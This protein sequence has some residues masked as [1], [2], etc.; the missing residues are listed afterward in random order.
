MQSKFFHHPQFLY[1]D[2]FYYLFFGILGI[3]SVILLYVNQYFK[4]FWTVGGHKQFT[5]IKSL[6]VYA[7][8]QEVK[9]TF[10]F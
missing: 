6:A 4:W 9:E 5:I 10:G 7:Q 2:I 8:K 1:N 3:F